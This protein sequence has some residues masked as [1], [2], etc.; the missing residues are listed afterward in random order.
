MNGCGGCSALTGPLTVSV[1]ICWWVCMCTV[2]MCVKIA[3][4]TPGRQ[5]G[6]ISPCR[7]L[8]VN[9]NVFFCINGCMQEPN[10]VFFNESCLFLP[11]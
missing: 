9:E 5:N 3:L 10:T 11:S 8:A 4:S 2:C 7:L 6:H 1:H